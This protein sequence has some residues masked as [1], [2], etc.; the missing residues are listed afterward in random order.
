MQ[1]EELNILKKNTPNVINELSENSE[2][3][4]IKL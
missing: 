2:V 4:N 3:I 1:N